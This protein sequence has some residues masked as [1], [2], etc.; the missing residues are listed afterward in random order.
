MPLGIAALMYAVVLSQVS[1]HP[2]D[3]DP[4]LGTPVSRPR[5]HFL[6]ELRVDSHP[7]RKERG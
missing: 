5:G 4:S 7:N 3:N 2:S 6:V 1:D